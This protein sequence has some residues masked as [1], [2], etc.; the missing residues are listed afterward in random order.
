MDAER[1]RPITGLQPNRAPVI[2][3]GALIVR[4]VMEKMAKDTLVV[5]DRGLRHGLIQEMFGFYLDPTHHE[6]GD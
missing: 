6:N 2:L 1:R 3:A 5:S 4:A